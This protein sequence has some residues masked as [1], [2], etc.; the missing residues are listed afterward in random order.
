MATGLRSKGRRGRREGRAGPLQHQGGRGQ[1]QQ[2]RRPRLGGVCAVREQ[3]R[4]LRGSSG[5]ARTVSPPTA[6]PR[7]RHGGGGARRDATGDPSVVPGRGV[8]RE[9]LPEL[10]GT[11]RGRGGRCRGVRR[12]PRYGE[13]P[14]PGAP[15]SRGALGPF[16]TRW[17]Q[18]VL[19]TKL[20]K[21]WS[22]CVGF[23]L[24]RLFA[25]RFPVK[26]T[27]STCKKSSLARTGLWGGFSWHASSALLRAFVCMNPKSF[28]SLGQH[29]PHQLI[30][31]LVQVPC[32][33]L[34]VR[35]DARSCYR[36]IWMA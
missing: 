24:L 30:V 4:G 20:Y 35:L 23:G 13:R 11:V 22:D 12:I 16:W 21:T 34:T 5:A 10:G 17:K 1:Q 27:L 6:A 25:R 19:V 32:S 31:E 3:R 33:L 28:L 7:A 9:A 2:R 26:K 15:G 8:R 36:L 18:S 14:V 29:L